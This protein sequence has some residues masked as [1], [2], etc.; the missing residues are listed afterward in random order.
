MALTAI[1]VKENGYLVTYE[2]SIM[3]IVL[4]NPYGKRDVV[5]QSASNVAEYVVNEN[6]LIWQELKA[7]A[8]IA[9]LISLISVI[10]IIWF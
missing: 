10:I 5:R 8:T 1:Q 9:I 6:G 4:F 7:R 2:R 3:L